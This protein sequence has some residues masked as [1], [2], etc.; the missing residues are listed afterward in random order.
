MRLWKTSHHWP[1]RAVSPGCGPQPLSLPLREAAAWPLELPLLSPPRSSELERSC[2]TWT[3]PGTRTVNF[4]FEI[5]VDAATRK[6]IVGGKAPKQVGCP[7]GFPPVQNQQNESAT[8]SHLL[9]RNEGIRTRIA[10]FKLIYKEARII[11]KLEDAGSFQRWLHDAGLPGT[12]SSA[13]AVS[14]VVVVEND[15]EYARHWSS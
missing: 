2:M 13:P 5:I 8:I 9:A 11:S 1:Q 15:A 4:K 3:R 14:L 6:T 12:T 7:A 10:P